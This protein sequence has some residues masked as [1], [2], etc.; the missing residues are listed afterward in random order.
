[1]ML[2]IATSHE[3][4]F[5]AAYGR[6]AGAVWRYLARR[7]G[8]DDLAEDLTAEVFLVAWRRRG[9]APTDSLPW[10]YGVA[11]DARGAPGPGRPA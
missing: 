5:R 7:L 6:H 1:M 9:D 2:T 11:R 10:L 4:R 8:D 3:E